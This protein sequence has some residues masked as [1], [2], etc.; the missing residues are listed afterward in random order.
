MGNSLNNKET[1]ALHIF[2]SGSSFL[3]RPPDAQK[4]GVDGRRS[5]GK[6]SITYRSLMEQGWRM[7]RMLKSGQGKAEA[8]K[9][10]RGRHG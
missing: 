8:R 10:Q 5:Y 6:I 7:K 3:P 1:K 2:L 9:L 4:S